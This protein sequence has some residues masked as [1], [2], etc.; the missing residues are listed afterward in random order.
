[1]T[2]FIPLTGGCSC[3]ATRFR[4][5]AAPIIT[6]CCHCRYCQA[7]S[8]SAFNVNSMIETDHLTLTQGETRSSEGLRGWTGVQCAACGSGL[9]SHHPHLGRAIAFV[10]S[11]TLDEGERLTP[12]VHYFIRSKHPWIT[13]PQDVPAF[14]Q[15]G[16]PGKPGTRERITAAMEAGGAGNSVRKYTGEEA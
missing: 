7:G 6:H 4:M 10:G 2:A 5:E 16:D 13:L 15:L 8:G 3:G 1:M 9:W 12:E 14:E 11:G